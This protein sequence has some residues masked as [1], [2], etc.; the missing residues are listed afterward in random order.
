MDFARNERGVCMG[1]AWNIN[2]FLSCMK[3]HADCTVTV[4]NEPLFAF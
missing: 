1:F 2:L 3:A 4:V